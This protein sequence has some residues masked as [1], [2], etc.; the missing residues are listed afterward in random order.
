MKFRI[1][2][3]PKAGAGAAG[4]TIPTLQEVFQSQGI[5]P[6]IQAT[7]G[8]GNATELARRARDEHVDVIV[9]VGGDGTLNEVS[10]AYI[11]SDGAPLPG[12][13]LA[14]VP[15]GT[16]GDFRRVYGMRRDAREAVQRLLTAEPRPLDLGVA[17][18][19]GED[20]AP[21]RR[22]FVNILSF[23]ISGKLDRLVNETPKWLGGR[24]AFALGTLRSMA[25]YQNAPVVV[26]VDGKEWFRGRVF[27]V[28]IANGTSF[29][30]GMKVAPDARPDDGL[31]DVRVLGDLSL[32]EILPKWPSIYAGT[33]RHP[34]VTGTRGSV[35]E[36]ESADGRDVFIDADG[37][38]PGL[39]P[40]KAWIHP[41]ALRIRV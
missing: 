18:M 28:A 31:F 24:A 1:I 30:G 35:V 40:L 22:A 16:G 26:R 11:D 34:K 19:V 10:Q 32:V 39:L 3:N 8:P 17:D 29:G 14:L 20:G 4:R 36:A 9:V 21:V 6:D 13:D 41:G 25:S 2:V 33:L 15:A 5:T 12:P 27:A 7:A 38:T 23:G 37:E